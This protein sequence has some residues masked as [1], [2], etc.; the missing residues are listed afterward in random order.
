MTWAVLDTANNLLVCPARL[1]MWHAEFVAS[2]LS[3][4]WE[5]PGRFVAVKINE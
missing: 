4:A 3:V 5:Q 1:R 2:L